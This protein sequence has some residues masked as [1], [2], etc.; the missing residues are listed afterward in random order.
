[1][2]FF[3]AELVACSISGGGICNFLTSQLVRKGGAIYAKESTVTIHDSSLN[4]NSAPAHA[5]GES[6]SS[7]N[8]VHVHI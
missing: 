8:I 1:M 4:S 3:L 7:N 2:H 6:V 5:P